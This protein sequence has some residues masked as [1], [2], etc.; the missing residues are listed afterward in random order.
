MTPEVFENKTVFVG[1]TALELGDVLAVPVYGSMP[2]IVLQAMAAETVNQGAPRQLP[3][4]A[5]LA[6]LALWALSP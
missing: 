3:T 5:S 1:A 2:G 6:L 4:W